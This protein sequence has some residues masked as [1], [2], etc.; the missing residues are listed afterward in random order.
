[1]TD[2]ST[3]WLATTPT[4]STSTADAA[5]ALVTWIQHNGWPR[6]IFSDRGS[7]FTSA[8]W[9]QL[10]S[11][12]GI[13]HRKTTAYNPRGDSHAESQVGNAKSIIKA[14]V[15]SHP[16]CWDDASAWA[17]V[18]YNQSYHSTTGTTPYF[19]RHGREPHTIADTLFASSHA[20]DPLTLSN[21]V[22]RIRR[23]RDAVHAGVDRILRRVQR[24]NATI[25][26]PPT[27]TVGDRVYL[28]RIFPSRRSARIDRAFFWPYR[29]QLFTITHVYSEQHVRI[30]CPTASSRMRD[31]VVHV[32]RL[33]RHHARSEAL[34][35][36]D[37]LPSDDDEGV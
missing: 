12:F 15:Q 19:A 16:D 35:F 18:Y 24:H 7:S 30:V 4:V 27:F 22:H 8:V 6:R 25:R 14:I 20:P 32:H 29:R 31:Q 5:R 2:H 1:M 3:K 33:K 17:T 9:A 37:F 11:L 34:D 26:T 13:K 23:I 10:L 36:S 21:L 28:H